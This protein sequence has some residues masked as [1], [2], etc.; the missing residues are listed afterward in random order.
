MGDQVLIDRIMELVRPVLAEQALDLIDCTLRN[1]SGRWVLALKIDH[2]GATGPACRVTLD[3][4]TQA[5]RALVGVLDAEAHIP[6]AYHLEVSTPGPDRLLRD[7][8]DFERFLGASVTVRTREPIDGCSN[9]HGVLIAVTPE[10][11]EMMI[12]QQ[13]VCLAVGAIE[14]AHLRPEPTNPAAPVHRVHA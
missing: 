10:I 4:C 3:E 11:L 6:M 14:R 9:F 5:S 13:R 8:R 12:D 1:Q 7:Q 2:L